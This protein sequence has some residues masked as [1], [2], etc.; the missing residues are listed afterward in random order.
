MRGNMRNG[1]RFSHPVVS[2]GPER[3]YFQFI[4]TENEQTVEERWETMAAE[5]RSRLISIFNASPTEP[6]G[7][8][9]QLKIPNKN[10]LENPYLIDFLPA[11]DQSS[12]NVQRTFR[13]VQAITGEYLASVYNDML[14][15]AET[16]ELV[17]FRLRVQVI[18][19]VMRRGRPLGGARNSGFNLIPTH[20]K[21]R[22]LATH[23]GS[24]NRNPDA[25]CGILAFLL[26]YDSKRYLNDWEGWVIDAAMF[27]QQIG[28][29]DRFM[30]N[31]QFD[32]L[33]SLEGFTDLRVII[34]RI[35]REIEWSATGEDWEFKGQRTEEDKCSIYLMRDATSDEGHFYW[36]QSI[37]S[38]AFRKGKSIT[39]RKDCYVCMRPFQPH[40]FDDHIC[41][42]VDIP[43]CRICKRVFSS[44][45]S[46]NNH[47]AGK[48][49]NIKC[50]VCQRSY[51]YGSS[52]YSHHLKENCNAPKGVTRLWC[53]GCDRY[54]REDLEHKCT[55]FGFCRNCKHVPES[56]QEYNDHFCHIL[57][58]EEYWDPVTDNGKFN[59]HWFYDFETTGVLSENV[60]DDYD[61][62]CEN[63]FQKKHEVM[64]WCCRLMIPCSMT[65]LHVENNEFCEKVIQKIE[66]S[67]TDIAKRIKYQLIPDHS[68][69]RLYGKCLESFLFL[70]TD[71]LY[72]GKKDDKWLPTFWAHNGSKFDSKFILDHYLNE[73]KM[74]LAGAS[75]EEDDSRQPSSTL[76]GMNWK[77]QKGKSKQIKNV[78]KVN[79][80]GCKVLQ[81]AVKNVKFRCSH[82]H[83]TAPLRD[84]P[85]RF[86]LSVQVKKGEFPYPLLQ[87]E[88]W[89]KVFPT[90][91]SLE[92]FDIDSMSKPRRKEVL[93]WYESQPKNVP[94]DFDKELW[95]YLFTDVDVGCLVMEAYH[96]KSEE[97]HMDLW[98]KY[99]ERSD[100]HL[101]PL[102][103]VTS[104]GWALA[105]YR[106]W[107]MPDNQLAI[108]R[109][110]EAKFI[111]DSL[112]GGRTDKRA[113][114]VELEK[115]TN[116]RI[117]YVDFKSLYPSVQKCNV[118]GTHYPIGRP[119]WIKRADKGPTTNEDLIKLMGNKTGFIRIDTSVPK[120]YV[121]HPTLHRVGSH[122]NDD[123]S[124]KLLFELD[125]KTK[126]IYAWPEIEEAIRCGEVDVTRV[127]EGLLFEKGTSV[128]DDYVDFFFAVKDQAEIDKN[129]GLRS[130]AKLLLNSLWGKLGQ[131]SYSTREWV[132]DSTRRDFLLDKFESGEFEMQSCTIKD[133]HRV[134]F[135]YRIPNDYNNLHD[136]APQIAAFV[137]MWGRVVLHQ[138]LLS[139]HGARAL[140]CDTDSAIVYLREGQDEM[141][142]LGNKLGDL[143]DEV[144]K[145]APRNYTDAYISEVVLV[146]PKTYGLKI[147]S[148]AVPEPY[149]KVVCKGFE[150][151]YANSRNIHF[152][153]FKELVFTKYN[154]NTFMN[155]K[156]PR[157]HEDIPRR[158]YIRGG[159]RLTFKSS[160]ATN[161]I[162]P[163]EAYVQKTL[164]GEYSKGRKHPHDAR[165]ISPYSRKK[166][167][168]PKKTFLDERDKHFE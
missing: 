29:T 59:C 96:E 53:D 132:A 139:V 76:K 50:E 103:K 11:R 165:F 91:P 34:F 134:F 2:R 115:D 78:V 61:P 37:N 167:G 145:I 142:F 10:F 99:P 79:I 7:T 129:E 89:G 49:D 151:S 160:L 40:L 35:D 127:Y 62:S 77:E 21:K 107:F 95:E 106:T 101:S 155:K 69:I 14:H 82:A 74:D 1:I 18:G 25:P 36:I 44:N 154:I 110:E 67:S 4:I 64:A 47:Y 32:E 150:P 131:R 140:Y 87:R 148:P 118:H 24:A 116:D 162:S 111:R 54:Y 16:L 158:L 97:M 143:T 38:T 8:K 163:V 20:L 149:Y 52:C 31:N 15:S 9:N 121:T 13:S 93:D 39:G 48:D 164:S 92:Y 57:P 135:E 124:S 12:S 125:A 5:I 66:N 166:I 42:G 55:D 58:L 128:F 122:S 46:L 152:D 137:S 105:M 70:C 100:K 112:R 27:G 113:N 72:Q 130:L 98:N 63:T 83:H 73:E 90:F 144:K 6:A 26:G 147:E 126:Q 94:W 3:L 45:E 86:G 51:F 60:P 108:L 56:K 109:K 153:S 102:Q 65:K 68:S 75:Y 85:A 30:R 168:P 43:Q 141:S 88:N 23:P 136:T 159:N 114:W 22:G 17:G 19:K 81:M 28:L 71:I 33:V 156:R 157:D 84:L 123:K 119:T 80:V 133:D 146:A 161:R 117:T 41:E 138:K 104:P 120:K